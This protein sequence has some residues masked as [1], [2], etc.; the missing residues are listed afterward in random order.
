MPWRSCG[1]GVDWA[2]YYRTSQS[3]TRCT[4]TAAEAVDYLLQ[5]GLHQAEVIEE[6]LIGYAPGRCLRAWLTSLG[7]SL[8]DLQQAGLVNAE[9]YDTYSHRIVFPLE[10]NLY[11]FAV[12]TLLRW[13][14]TTEL[15]LEWATLPAHH[16]PC[17]WTARLT[18]VRGFAQ[19][20]SATDP[21]T[22]IP[23]LGL[24]PYR[25]NRARPYFYSDQE[26]QQPLKAAKARPGWV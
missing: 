17:Q 1:I 2:L 11:R 25:P 9:G 19:Y 6:L 18:T 16:Q 14:I 7:Y 8:A 23:P 13:Y 10:G 4:Y 12:D 22:E 21:T 3:S 26:I 24:L 20:W 15:A 5:R